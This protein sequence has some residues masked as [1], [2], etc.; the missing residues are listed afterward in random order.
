MI[1]LYDNENDQRIGAIDEGQLHFLINSMEEEA[2]DD[3]DY[4]IDELTLEYLAARGADAALLALLRG[5][6]AGRKGMTF[7]WGE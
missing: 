1:T 5:A 2:S 4:Y 7:R 6:L 3:Q